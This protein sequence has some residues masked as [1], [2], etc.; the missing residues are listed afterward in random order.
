MTRSYSSQSSWVPPAARRSRGA[1]RAAAPSRCRREDRPDPR[2]RSALPPLPIASRRESP[3]CSVGEPA[4]ASAS[5]PTRRRRTPRPGHPSR[6]GRRS[7]RS[8][9]TTGWFRRAAGRHDDKAM[10]ERNQAGESGEIAH[11]VIILQRHD[12]SPW[13]GVE[14]HRGG[15]EAERVRDTVRSGPEAREIAESGR[16]VSAP[17]GSAVNLVPRSRSGRRRRSAR[18]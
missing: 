15:P 2:A 14:G 18:R 4:G 12:L 5:E 17:R 9:P 13:T 3:Q 10:V 16:V 8:P 11:H 7:R 6:D 1:A